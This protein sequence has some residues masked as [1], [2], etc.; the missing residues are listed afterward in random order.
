M[1]DPVGLL[2]ALV[3][4]GSRLRPRGRRG[5]DG[6]WIGPPD[7]RPGV[8]YG[9]SSANLKRIVAALAPLSRIFVLRRP[10][11][12]SS[13]T[14][15]RSCRI[16]AS[17][18]HGL[19]GDRSPRRDRGRRN[20]SREASRKRASGFSW[21]RSNVS[22]SARDALISS[23]TWPRGGRKDL[24][25]VAELEAIRGESGEASLEPILRWPDLL[26]S[27]SLKGRTLVRRCSRTACGQ[28]ALALGGE[29]VR[30]NK[31]S[32]G[33]GSRRVMG[34][35]RAAKSPGAGPVT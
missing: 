1:T 28:L 19:R 13:G 6:A 5:G 35:R 33:D 25:G 23:Q 12:P 17:L 10:A 7:A 2:T 11:S 9:R 30:R 27:P 21:V 16:E 20:G 32:T 31:A 8:V 4:A 29:T 3:R 26:P 14:S 15:G 22:A 18:L 24:E 34:T